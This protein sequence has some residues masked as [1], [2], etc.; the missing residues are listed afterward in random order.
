MAFRQCTVW[1]I[2]RKIRNGLTDKLTLQDDLPNRFI[3]L[4]LEPGIDGITP[5]RNVQLFKTAEHPALV[6]SVNRL[7]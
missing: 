6:R 3:I 1:F 4:L 5:R 7:V 2:K